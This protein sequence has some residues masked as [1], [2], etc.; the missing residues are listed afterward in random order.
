MKGERRGRGESSRREKQRETGDEKGKGNEQW[1]QT[2]T[3]LERRHLYFSCLSHNG[4]FLVQFGQLYIYCLLSLS[5]MGSFICHITFLSVISKPLLRNISM[6]LFLL[7]MGGKRK[8][9]FPD[10]YCT[11]IL[12]MKT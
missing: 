9:K 4:L 1:K 10:I 2:L 5:N 11:K 3:K 12:F 6:K 7:S 8:S